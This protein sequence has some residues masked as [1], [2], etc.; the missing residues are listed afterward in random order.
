M[1]F[2][3][4]AFKNVNLIVSYKIFKT[5]NTTFVNQSPYAK[6]NAKETKEMTNKNR[7]INRNKAQTFKINI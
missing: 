2:P 6:T 3:Q 4:I 5:I 1:N 7:S